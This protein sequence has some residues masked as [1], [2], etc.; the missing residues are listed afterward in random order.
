[1]F[2]RIFT[3]G[4]W[5]NIVLIAKVLKSSSPHSFTWGIL[6]FLKFSVKTGDYLLKQY[7]ITINQRLVLIEINKLL[8]PV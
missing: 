5:K 3:F 2:Y 8:L 6:Q 4:S 1:M 7:L